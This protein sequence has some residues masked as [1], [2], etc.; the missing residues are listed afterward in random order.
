MIQYRRPS[1]LTIVRCVAILAIASAG[2]VHLLIVPEQFSH[3]VAHGSFFIF[4]G[5]AQ[6]LW[7]AAFWRF[8]SKTSY[9]AGLG[10]SGGMVILWALTQLVAIPYAP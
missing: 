1:T 5:L 8:P 7:A 10:L 6:V 2:A 3:G 4:L 9:W